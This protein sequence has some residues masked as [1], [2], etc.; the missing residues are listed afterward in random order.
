MTNQGTQQAAEGHI[1]RRLLSVVVP[2]FFNEPSL[3]PLFEE[4]KA[5]EGRLRQRAVDLELI[6][7]DD[8][9]GDGSLSALL[10]IHTARPST[11]VIKLTRNF[12][13]ATAVKTGLRRASGDALVILAADLQDPV[14]QIDAMV[15][16][17]LQGQ[18]FVICVRRTRKDPWLNRLASAVYYRLVRRIVIQGYPIGGFDMMLMTRQI[19]RHLADSPPNTNLHLLAFWLGFEPTVLD[20]DRPARPFGRS[21]WSVAKRLKL[22]ADTVTGFSVVPIRLMS[23]LGLLAAGVSFLYAIFMFVSALSRGVSVPGFA[24]TV[25]LISFFGGMILLM[26]G[27]IGEYLWRIFENTAHKPDGVVETVYDDSEA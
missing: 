14:A 22:V 18:P 4:L 2:V 5:L 9:S 11:V 24:T 7:V 26:L 15:D 19:Y 27:M 6:F 23:M 25:V 3:P 13:A 16:A 10:A 21:R 20:Y 1:G 12:G 17:W 8:G